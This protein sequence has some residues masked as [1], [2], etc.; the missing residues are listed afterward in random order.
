MPM[1]FRAFLLSSLM[2]VSSP[3]LSAQG[4]SSSLDVATDADI[5][6]TLNEIRYIY[7]RAPS[8]YKIKHPPTQRA[9]S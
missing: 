8:K 3:H 2:L 5:A 9:T 7:E 1:I 6:L 4:I